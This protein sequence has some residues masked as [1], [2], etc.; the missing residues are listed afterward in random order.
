MLLGKYRN[1]APL[2][3]VTEG[4]RKSVVIPLVKIQLE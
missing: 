4:E 2:I 3:S 1:L